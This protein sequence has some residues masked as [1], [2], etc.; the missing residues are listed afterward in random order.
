MAQK[1]TPKAGNLMDGT[2]EEDNEFSEDKR[3]LMVFGGSLVYE[4]HR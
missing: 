1:P 4:S 3:Y 2:Q